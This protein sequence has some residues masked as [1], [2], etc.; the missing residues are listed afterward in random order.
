MY[1]PDNTDRRLLKLLA[2]DPT[3]TRRDCA[4]E[5]GFSQE[6]VRRRTQRLKDEKWLQALMVP[7]WGQEAQISVMWVLSCESEHANAVLND[8]EGLA[9]VQWAA[10]TECDVLAWQYLGGMD[11]YNDAMVKLSCLT[12]V[13]TCTGRMLVSGP[14]MPWNAIED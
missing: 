10:Q 12:G 1:T 6:T 7:H 4:R 11:A 9:G 5:L 14:V 13:K 3:K 2:A 8:V